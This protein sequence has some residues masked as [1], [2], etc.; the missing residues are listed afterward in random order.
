VIEGTK[1]GVEGH[2]SEANEHVHCRVD[3]ML[4]ASDS[5]AG[6]GP[7]CI[8]GCLSCCCIASC[9]SAATAEQAVA[10]SVLAANTASNGC[11]QLLYL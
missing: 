5:V 4:L 2:E 11:F 9:L 10:I 6:L 3:L 8:V 7:R 1:D